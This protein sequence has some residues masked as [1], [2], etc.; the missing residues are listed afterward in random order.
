MGLTAEA[1]ALRV[2]LEAAVMAEVERVGPDAFRRRAVVAPF[3]TRG[4][5]QTTAYRWVNEVLGSGRPGQHIARRVKASAAERAAR[6]SDPAAD[7]AAEVAA[8]LPVRARVEDVMGGA[9]IPIVEKLRVA[10]T[11]V[12]RVI[13][14]AKT[15]DGKVR[16]ARLLLQAT[17]NLRR[18][19]ETG[20]RIAE[21]MRDLDQ[22]DR[23]HAA[24]VEEIEKIDPVLAERVV[25]RLGQISEQWGG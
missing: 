15:E 17:E 16:N 23:F 13:A 18:C 24:I 11:D 21:A 19:L 7:A 4:V 9:S 1:A 22:V 2:E 10:M 8:K 12:E 3:V 6:A 14:H 5:P 20:L 25:L